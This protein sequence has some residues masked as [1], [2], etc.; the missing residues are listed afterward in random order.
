MIDA[1]FFVTSNLSILN[2]LR[3]HFSP[4]CQAPG[5]FFTFQIFGYQLK[6][7]GLIFASPWAQKPVINRGPQLPLIGMKIFPPVTHVFLAISETFRCFFF[8]T[9]GSLILLGML[10][11]ALIEIC[12]RGCSIACEVGL[13][14]QPGD[15]RGEDV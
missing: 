15:R 8:F 3:E 13:T 11:L 4:K 1:V 9:G 12:S 5:D 7:T 14:G 10:L 2:L 6:V